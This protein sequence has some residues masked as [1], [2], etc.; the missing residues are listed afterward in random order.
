MYDPAPRWGHALVDNI[1]KPF[2]K[3]LKGKELI[4]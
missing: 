3:F 1:V 4:L 2:S